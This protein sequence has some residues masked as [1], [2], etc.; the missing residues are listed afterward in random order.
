VCREKLNKKELQNLTGE[1]RLDG[2]KGAE[3][4]AE[5]TFLPTDY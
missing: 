1:S 2:G 5:T 3:K 4:W